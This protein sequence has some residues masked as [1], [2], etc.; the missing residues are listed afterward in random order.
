MSQF[1]ECLKTKTT[2][3]MENDIPFTLKTAE[4]IIL[5]KKINNLNS[6]FKKLR[7]FPKSSPYSDVPLFV[8]VSTILQAPK[9][10]ETWGPLCILLSYLPDLSPTFTPEITHPLA[11]ALTFSSS[12]HLWRL[13]PLHPY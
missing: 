4:T 6:V 13:S 11:S 3:G 5:E 9:L 10:K 12:L 1:T 2:E 8:K 7:S